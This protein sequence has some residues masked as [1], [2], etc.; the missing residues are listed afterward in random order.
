MDSLGDNSIKDLYTGDNPLKCP[1]CKVVK[2]AFKRE[3]G[4]ITEIVCS[5]CGY[6]L[7]WEV[8]Q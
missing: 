7:A 1:D 4:D 8:R 3:D 5:L 6:R 2:P